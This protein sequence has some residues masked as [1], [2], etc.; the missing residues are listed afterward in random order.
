MYNRYI[1]HSGGYERVV[2]EDGQPQG[3]GGEHHQDR[4][5]APP[6]GAGGGGRGGWRPR[7]LLSPGLENLDRGDI[8]LMLI[9]LLL[10]TDGDDLEP[11]I[12]LGLLLLFG[13]GGR[14]RGEKG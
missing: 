14:E 7:R 3:A 13:L 2:M 11:V 1:P 6:R 5:P 10:L 4:R 9:L 12:T 8:L